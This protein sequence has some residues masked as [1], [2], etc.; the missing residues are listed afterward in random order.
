MY[1]LK[2]FLSIEQ[3]KNVVILTGSSL[4][5][6]IEYVSVIEPPVENF[7]RKNELVLSTALGCTDNEEHFFK[8]VSDIQS[9]EPAA[10]VLSFKPESLPVPESIIKFASEKSL[11]ILRIPWECRFSEIIELVFSGINTKEHNT[12]LKYKDIQKTLLN[13]FFS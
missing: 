13:L 9:C 2:D 3:L 7:V 11:P 12:E 10:L 6:C 4:N 8:F 1:T 5:P